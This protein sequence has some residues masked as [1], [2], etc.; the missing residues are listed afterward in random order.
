MIELLDRDTEQHQTDGGA[1]LLTPEELADRLVPSLPADF[2]RWQA[3][4]I[5]GCPGWSQGRERNERHLDF[6]GGRQRAAT[7]R[8][9]G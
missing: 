2:A 4:G 6:R 5:R 7:D 3:G 9:H 1:P 8:G